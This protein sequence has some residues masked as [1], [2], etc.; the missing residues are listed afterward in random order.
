MMAILHCT[1]CGA[2]LSGPISIGPAIADANELEWSDGKPISPVGVAIESMDPMQKS[3]DPEHP[4]KLE[5]S[6]QFWMNP[7]DTEDA[8]ELVDDHCRL[9]GCCGLDGCDGPNMRCRR[10][11]AEV[12]TRQSDC[13]TADVFIPQPGATNW[14]ST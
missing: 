6:P 5:F 3:F 1:A 4:A 9:N 7:R 10:C 8:V 2:A 13:W 11:K 14:K 12:G